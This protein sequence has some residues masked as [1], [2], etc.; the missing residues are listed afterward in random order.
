ML[1]FH[2][3]VPEQEGLGVVMGVGWYSLSREPQLGAHHSL[4]Q[5]HGDG[6]Y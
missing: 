2:A 6:V 1:P 3:V 5:L 4:G